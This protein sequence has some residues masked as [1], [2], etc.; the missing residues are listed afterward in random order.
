MAQFSMKLGNLGWRGRIGLVVATAIGLAAAIALVVLSLGL[1]LVLLP[2][3]SVAFV[4][5]RWPLKKLMDEAA[6]QR[7]GD[8]R[9][10]EIDYSV[11]DGKD[12]NRN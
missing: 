11:I 5:G 10:I 3:V 12:R 8:Q 9:T 6:Q 1:A 7:P 2:V 4:I